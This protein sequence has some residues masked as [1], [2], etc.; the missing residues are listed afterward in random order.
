MSP[1]CDARLTKSP[2][3]Q[4]NIISTSSIT[5]PSTVLLVS[6]SV[7]NAF[8]EGKAAVNRHKHA[9]CFSDSHFSKRW[10]ALGG[11]GTNFAATSTTYVH[12]LVRISEKNLT[13]ITPSICR[14]SSLR[15][16]SPYPMTVCLPHEDIFQGHGQITQDSCWKVPD[17][18]WHYNFEFFLSFFTAGWCPLWINGLVL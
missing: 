11:T 16:V 14:A 13:A 17:N 1:A 3:D 6:W 2:A 18:N 7:K 5:I 15:Q 12:T 8:Y 4:W 9:D 10:A